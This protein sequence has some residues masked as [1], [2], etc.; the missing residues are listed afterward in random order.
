[1]ITGA[2]S[3]I[4]LLALLANR[5][6]TSLTLLGVIIG[7]TS[8][9]TIISA[10][11][12]MMD[13]VEAQLDKLGP[14]TFIIA[15]FDGVVT[16]EE[17]YLE[18][19]KRK[20]IDIDL[21]DEIDESCNLCEKICPRSFNNAQIKYGSQ[22]LKNVF[23][24]G[25]TSNF[26]DIV[27]FEV[28]QGRFHA[29]GDDFEKR[30]VVFIGEL[31][32][33]TFFEGID[34]IGKTIKLDGQKYTV[35]GV[36]NKQGSM[37]GQNR[38]SFCVIPLT[39]HIKQFGQPGR[40][41]SILVKAR[42]VEVLDETMDQ[43]RMVL[44]SNRHVPYNKPDD[45]SLITADAI[46]EQLNS[47]TKIFRLGLVGISSISLVVGGIVVMN[48]MMVSVTERTREIGIRKAIGAKQSHILGQFLIEAL[49]T[50]FT[51]GVAGIVFG[52]LIA[53]SLVNMIDMQIQPSVFAITAGLVISIGIGVVFGIYPAMKA[54]RLD[55]IKALSYE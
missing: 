49:M 33:E 11:E 6:R 18:M 50:T 30:H 55:P 7:V 54:A 27:D 43:V 51:G 14:S 46:L 5:L 9:M 25:S 36:A 38:D 16:S 47:I 1:M 22:S 2:L 4:A 48:I 3:K 13:G 21:V 35:I 17:E 20:P 45:F 37:F 15:A 32:R 23:V 10:L 8:V 29:P 31:L 41:S 52:Y 34:P 12:G 28:E 39:A 53:R 26:I 24:I 44:R 40:F 19:M 42:S